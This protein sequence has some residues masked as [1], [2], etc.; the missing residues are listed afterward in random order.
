MARSVRAAASAGPAAAFGLGLALLGA[1]AA[2]A[3]AAFG[4]LF[5]TAA[6]SAAAAAGGVRVAVGHL[7]KF[8]RAHRDDL[9]VEVERLARG[10]P[11][12]THACTRKT[13]FLQT[14]DKPRHH[15]IRRPGKLDANAPRHRLSLT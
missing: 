3:T 7:G 4:A 2:S 9:D 15:V 13:V 6:P 5:G 11:S 10:L 8:R 14:S 1:R 12:N